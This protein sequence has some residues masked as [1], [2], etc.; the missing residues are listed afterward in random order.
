MQIE[1][2]LLS[3]DPEGMNQL[4]YEVEVSLFHFKKE[5]PVWKQFSNRAQ[6]GIFLH[7]L[8]AIPHAQEGG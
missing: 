6:E 5:S 1:N 8:F 4:R 3:E 2:T 7:Y